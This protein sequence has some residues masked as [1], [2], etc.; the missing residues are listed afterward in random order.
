MVKDKNGSLNNLYYLRRNA[1]AL[2]Q[3]ILSDIKPQYLPPE[4]I[5]EILHELEVHEIELMLQNENLLKTQHELEVSR[6]RYFDLYELAPVGYFYI[7]EK[8]LILEANLAGANLLDVKR[9]DMIKKPFTQYISSKDQDIYYL[10]RKQ[11]IDANKSQICELRMKRR[12][13]D[14]FWARLESRIVKGVQSEGECR[15]VMSDITFLKQAENDIHNLNATLEQKVA[16][17]T[18]EL[19]KSNGYF[20]NLFNYAY[21][22][23]IVWNPEFRIIR[24]NKAFEKL[25]GRKS[26]DMID[27]PLDILFPPDHVE[28]SLKLIKEKTGC[29]QG[30]INEVIIQHSDGSVRTLLWSYGAI[31]DRDE[32]TPIASIALGQDITERKHA[33]AEKIELLHQ[34]F[35][36]RKLESIGIIAGGIAHDFN[37]L[38]TVILGNIELCRI[39]IP[40]DSK[41]IKNL[42]SAKKACLNAADLCEQMLD[43]AGKGRLIVNPVNINE[44]FD[45]IGEMLSVSISKKVRLDYNLALDLPT[46]ISDER[47]I[48]QILMNL[49]LNASEAIGD[50]D[51][52]ITVSTSSI[53]LDEHADDLKDMIMRD[54]LKNGRYIYLKVTDTGCGIDE[55]TKSKIFDPFFTTKFIGRGLGLAAVQGI[56]RSLGGGI[57]VNSEP[58]KGSDFMICIPAIE[59]EEIVTDFQAC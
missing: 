15:I 35:N 46:L 33:E 50:N 37:N 20:E 5:Q 32:K 39:E 45:E 26:A 10:H 28:S 14:I 2:S 31:F 25:T 56:V 53:Y 27:K 36:A 51:G 43:Y 9:N 13:G 38:L 8:G 12:E 55:E 34:L 48:K 40:K 58:G 41:G 47:Q 29:E 6:S 3:N 59:E 57:S 4:K 44:V 16:D 54:N 21:T 11:T 52:V 17:R 30:K 24:F 42:D 23:I 22:P 18:E 49:I 1:E 7:S 19:R